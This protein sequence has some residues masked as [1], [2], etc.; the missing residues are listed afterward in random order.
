[1]AG[2]VLTMIEGDLATTVESDFASAVTLKGPD[3]TTYA[4]SANDP[5]GKTPLYGSARRHTE[6]IDDGGNSVITPI[7]S[8]VMRI[9]SLAR[10]PKQAENWAVNFAFPGESAAWYM[11]DATRAPEYD[12]AIGYVILFPIKAQQS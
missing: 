8:L 12:Y 2:E 9:T 11:L 3:G 4:T 7:P 5:T 10:A 6:R 1:M